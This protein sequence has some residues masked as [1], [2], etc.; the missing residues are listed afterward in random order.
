MISELE[1]LSFNLC[2]SVVLHI[3]V[4][5]AFTKRDHNTLRVERGRNSPAE[6]AAH[7]PKRGI[8]SSGIFLKEVLGD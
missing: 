8:V 4:K 6:P 2:W 5:A 3:P 7:H 1:R